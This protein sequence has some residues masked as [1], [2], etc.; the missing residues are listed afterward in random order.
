MG[1]W[2]KW[3]AEI[4]VLGAA[5]LADWVTGTSDSRPPA[6]RVTSPTGTSGILLGSVHD[7]VEG[8]RQP[9]TAALFKAA[10]SYEAAV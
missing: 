10:R 4:T 5:L 3:G 7:G 1:R 9:D 8:L 2:L 6:L